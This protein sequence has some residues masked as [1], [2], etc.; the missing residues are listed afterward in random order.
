MEIDGQLGNS[1]ISPLRELIAYHNGQRNLLLHDKK[2]KQQKE[3]AG[4]HTQGS[5]FAG[6]F[7]YMSCA[8]ARAHRHAPPGPGRASARVCSSFSSSYIASTR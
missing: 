8:H 4:V 5:D 1:I 3:A 2:L 7:T 6:P